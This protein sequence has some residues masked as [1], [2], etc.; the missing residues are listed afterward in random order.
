LKLR[1]L[2]RVLIRIRNS[3]F[4]IPELLV[5]DLNL[6][7][8]LEVLDSNPSPDPELKVPIIENRENK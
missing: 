7:P 2:I 1:A 8:E 3:T 5:P 6:D 4:W